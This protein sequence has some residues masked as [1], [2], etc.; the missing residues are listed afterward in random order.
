MDCVTRNVG[1]DCGG[2]M[3]RMCELATTIST[4]ERKY[5]A[6]SR[7]MKRAERNWD[8]AAYERAEA[9]QDALELSEAATYELASLMRKWGIAPD[10]LVMLVNRRTV[11]E[12][13]NALAGWEVD[14]GAEP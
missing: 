5:R 3:T 11:E 10:D 12:V 2:D 14:W 9:E 8:R 4:L 13:F 1:D 6:L 7:K